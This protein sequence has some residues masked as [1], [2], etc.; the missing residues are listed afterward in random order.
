MEKKK[1]VY[2]EGFCRQGHELTNDNLAEADFKLGIKRCKICRNDYVRN[3]RAKMN[4]ANP[5]GVYLFEK[6]MKLWEKYRIRLPQW[7]EMF[8]SQGGKCIT[9]DFIFANGQSSN[10][11]DQAC[12]D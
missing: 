9:C 12:V 8:D 2:K 11:A 5:N 10:K 6:D 1:K 7:Q 3:R 4:E